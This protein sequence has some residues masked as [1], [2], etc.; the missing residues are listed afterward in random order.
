M[1]WLYAQQRGGR[2][3]LRVDFPTGLDH[4][5]TRQVEGLVAAYEHRSEHL[6]E[7]CGDPGRLSDLPCTHVCCREC[8]AFEAEVAEGRAGA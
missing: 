6:C 5:I 2:L 1:D 4:E 7:H 8:D 3:E